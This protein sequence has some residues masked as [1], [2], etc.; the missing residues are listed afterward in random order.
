MKP[1][2]AVELL[3]LRDRL[4]T[5]ARAVLILISSIVEA[6][7]M[8]DVVARL[9]DQMAAT[10]Q[11]LIEHGVVHNELVAHRDATP[12]GQLE[13]VL[14]ALRDMTLRIDQQTILGLE[15]LR[16]GLQPG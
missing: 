14:N 6:K 16:K 15:A 10:N 5:L 12:P 3:N 11:K 8:T 9:V 2:D 7:H 1:I 4:D 13:A